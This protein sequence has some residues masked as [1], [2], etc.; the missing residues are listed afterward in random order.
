MSHKS[1]KVF[2][3][4]LDI[5]G[6]K[7][8]VLKNGIEKVQRDITE[9]FSLGAQI[10]IAHISAARHN[11]SVI[12]EEKVSPTRNI[13]MP[14]GKQKSQVNLNVANINS[15]LMFDSIVLWS[16]NDTESDLID[17]LNVVRFMLHS[18][19]FF[20]L[21]LRGAVSYGE[22]YFQDLPVSA[23]SIIKHT[24]LVS[25]AQIHAMSLEKTQEWSG[26][27][28]DKSIVAKCQEA[29]IDLDNNKSFLVTKYPV[30]MKT[31]E[32]ELYAL[33]WGVKT[34]GKKICNVQ[35]SVKATWPMPEGSNE[36]I[37]NKIENT[38]KFIEFC[39]KKLN[40]V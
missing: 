10:A 13:T 40:L 33:I 21:P 34:S 37:L 32:M 8:Y 7:S 35:E 16:N 24:V 1:P 9:L 2:V 15:I 36:A 27:V 19:L 12:E 5:L 31:G 11:L 28:L 38:I 25:P 29:E 23:F 22:L 30:P 20:G 14:D 3:A 26:C 17:L 18:H 39:C 6:F 4:Y